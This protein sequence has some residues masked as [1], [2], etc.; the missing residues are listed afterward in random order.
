MGAG[1]AGAPTPAR[2]GPDGA[3]HPARPPGAGANAGSVAAA[4]NAVFQSAAR[5]RP[6]GPRPGAP[7]GRSEPPTR[8]PDEIEYDRVMDR[9]AQLGDQPPKFDLAQNDATH[10]SAHTI[11]RHGPEIPLR[12]DPNG[13]SV[14]GRIYG[15]PPWAKVEG[16]S[17]QWTDP[18]T[19]NREINKYVRDNW[20][21]IRDD[22]ALDTYHDGVFD[23]GH[24]IGRGY[25]NK[26]MYGAGP[27]QAEY[28]ETSL[29]R[30]RIRLVAGSDPVEPFVVTAFP[31]GLG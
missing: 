12:R 20:N 13:R 2:H 30:V 11:E 18:S 23:A 16:K 9:H 31:A 29:V 4:E 22:L 7:G 1:D 27:R 3:S 5:G 10:G 25:Y 17:Y 26:G 6:G 14:E 24:R 19:M 15:D 8:T 21:S 28:G